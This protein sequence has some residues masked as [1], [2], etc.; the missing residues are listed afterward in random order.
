[1]PLHHG[2]TARTIRANIP[3]NIAIERRHGRP[4]R[5]AIAIGYST[6]RRDAKK[7]HIKPPKGIR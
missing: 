2:R 7:A 3:R 4:A 1:M 6:A 5:Q